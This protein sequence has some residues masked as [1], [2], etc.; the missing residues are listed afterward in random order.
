MKLLEII[1]LLSSPFIRF[2][3]VAIFIGC[4]LPEWLLPIYGYV[5][6]FIIIGGLIWMFVSFI[7][8]VC[9]VIK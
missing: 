3:I 1:C 2:V 7:V 9:K 8:D 5:L 4:F 6:G